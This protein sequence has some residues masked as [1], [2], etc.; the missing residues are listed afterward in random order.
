MCITNKLLVFCL[1]FC[2][3]AC[4]KAPKVIP[5][6]T[7]HCEDNIQNT[8]PNIAQFDAFI[9]QKVTEGLPGMTMLIETPAGIWAGAAGMADIPNKISVQACNIGRIGSITK[10]FTATLI[11]K[12][13][14][15][16]QLNL[17]DKISLYLAPEIVNKISN[18][19]LATVEQL[20]SHT[21]G[22]TDYSDQIDF[23]ISAL[24]DAN[25]LWTAL[26][27]LAFIYDEPAQF[28]PNEQRKYSNSNYTLL[29]LIAENITEKSGATLF[30]EEIFTPLGLT[31]TS[32][33]QDNITPKHIVRG[34]SDEEENSVLIDRTAFTFAHSSMEGGAMSSVADLRT[35]I[36]A[37]MTPNVLFSEAT[38]Q[39]MITVKPPS[40]KDHTIST[41]DTSLKFDGI[42]LGWFNLKTPYGIGYGHG[43][44]LR[45]YQSF[46]VYFPDRN[47][48][49]CYIINGHDGQLDELE[50]NMRN[51]EL[52][53]L[54][55]EE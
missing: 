42:G 11:L 6:S 3:A 19:E 45:G 10:T 48:T 27:E 41:K 35:F 32:F 4:V 34:Y 52:V 47:V 22:I 23:S 40:G 9:A 7:Y 15:K 1:I 18:A 12:L 30:Q 49:V 43:G 38:I 28:A 5:L 44:S 14:E 36:Q 20:L 50:D 13:V 8:H 25:K 54:L 29:G 21:S 17:S 46:M 39:E 26:D 51:N 16:G 31:N 33:N 53:P 55:F 24:N 37:A 2:C